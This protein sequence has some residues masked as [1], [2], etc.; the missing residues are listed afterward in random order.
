[1]KLSGMGGRSLRP[2]CIAA[3]GLHHDNALFLNWNN[4]IE[5][6][7]CCSVRHGVGGHERHIRRQ[8]RHHSRRCCALCL[9]T[10]V[11]CALA[12]LQA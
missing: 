10:A 2:T 3:D 8:G 11:L 7:R 6:E 9:Q 1:M 4:V 12:L 5:N